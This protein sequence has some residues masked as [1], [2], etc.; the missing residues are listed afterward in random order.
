MK[1]EIDKD[2][3]VFI[4]CERLDIEIV[5]KRL[6][7][8][9]NSLEEIF[10]VNYAEAIGGSILMVG[11]EKEEAITREG[12]D[13]K[14]FPVVTPVVYSSS[15]KPIKKTKPK[16]SKSDVKWARREY[17]KFC[18]SLPDSMR[19]REKERRRVHI[20]KQIAQK[21]NMSLTGINYWLKRNEKVR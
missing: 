6:R 17:K 13:G 16:M 7:Y 20:R 21:F 1:I 2:Y 19:N 14:K 18:D 11:S 9:K 5:K 4:T 15:E 8:L 3:R 10:P 12:V